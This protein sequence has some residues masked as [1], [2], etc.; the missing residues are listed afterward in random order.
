MTF[1]SGGR[2]GHE[3]AYVPIAQLFLGSMPR[4][5]GAWDHSQLSQNRTAITV[6]R[7]QI[8]KKNESFSVAGPINTD[9]PG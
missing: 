1:L 4:V 3:K 2:P 8:G 5:P 7:P 9:P 6:L